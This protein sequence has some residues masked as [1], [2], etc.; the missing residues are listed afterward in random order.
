MNRGQART[1]IGQSA[2]RRNT[3]GRSNKT[4]GVTVSAS[5]FLACHQYCCASSSLPWGLNL[6]YVALSEARRQG[7]SLGT[8]VSSPPSSVNVSAIE[9]KLK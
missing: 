6:K 3:D 1:S 7:F 2:F 9:I 4:S 5:A 8:P